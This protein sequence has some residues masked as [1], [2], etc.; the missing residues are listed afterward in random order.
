M[1]RDKLLRPFDEVMRSAEK[2]KVPVIT[3]LT[4]FGV[5]DGFIGVMKGVMLQIA[6][7][8]RLIDIAHD[9]PPFSIEGGAFLNQWSYG[10][11][12]QGTA[13]LCVVDPG[14]GTSR[15]MLAVQVSG[16]FFIAP[17]NGVLSPI[18]RI[19][20][21][22]TV[23][24]ITNTKYWMDKVS[25]TFHGRDIFSPVAAHLA[26]GVAIEEL[27]E[28][29][30]DPIMLPELELMFREDAITC[31]IEYVDRFGNLITTLPDYRCKD[32]MKANHVYSES[33][34]IQAGGKIINGI[35][36]SYGEKQAGELLAVFDGFNRLEIS[37]NQGSAKTI[38]GLQY[39]D[40][41]LLTVK[42]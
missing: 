35:S 24:S 13:H 4:D 23:V 28:M 39:G 19:N 37:V 32:W 31:Q 38:T 20:E 42:S 3:L 33:I 7:Q 27:G 9:L 15:R 6:P 16:H 12:P 5:A 21:P 11:F 29:I 41:V 17:D 2:N 22:K 34:Q 14:V 25:H 26:A 8:A 36:S 1:S 10:Y 18:L 40:T 30:D